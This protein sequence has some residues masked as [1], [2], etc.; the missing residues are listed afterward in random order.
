MKTIEKMKQAAVLMWQFLWI[1]LIGGCRYW[2][3]GGEEMA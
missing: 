2:L 3:L 1:P